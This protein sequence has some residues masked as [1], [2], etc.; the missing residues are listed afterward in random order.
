MGP[1]EL[2]SR[3]GSESNPLMHFGV[4][5]QEN[6]TIECCHKV[7]EEFSILSGSLKVAQHER[8]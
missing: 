4:R 3:V 7:L 2:E 5:S 8:C 1:V 6:F